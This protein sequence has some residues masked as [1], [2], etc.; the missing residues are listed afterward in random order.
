MEIIV[1]A[2][3]LIVVFL[4]A[5]ILDLTLEVRHLTQQLADQVEMEAASRSNMMCY[6]PAEPRAADK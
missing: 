4:I 5:W 1:F 6:R 2:L 3:V